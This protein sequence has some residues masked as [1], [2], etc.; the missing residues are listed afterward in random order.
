MRGASRRP[1]ERD[2]WTRGRGEV[3]GG[4][5]GSE[6][7]I[8]TKN[9]TAAHGMAWV[10]KVWKYS[11]KHTGSEHLSPSFER[12]WQEPGLC[13]LQGRP[14]RAH[15]GSVRHQWLWG[16]VLCT[17]QIIIVLANTVC[18]GVQEKGYLRREAFPGVFRQG[19]QDLINEEGSMGFI[20]WVMLGMFSPFTPLTV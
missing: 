16:V 18:P 3:T 13:S 9:P 8:W 10:R 19:P 5:C 7:G 2:C 6:A 4:G 11:S 15:L 12:Y 1:R 14:V 20:R 17:D